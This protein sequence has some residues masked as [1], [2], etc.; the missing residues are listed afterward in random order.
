MQSGWWS[1]GS[2]LALLLLLSG[3]S[4]KPAGIT[5]QQWQLLTPAQ[6]QRAREQLAL[7]DAE[8]KARPPQLATAVQPS[9]SQLAEES[10]SIPQV[11][12]RQ[13]IR[14]AVAPQQAWLNGQWQPA[15]PLLL[16][17]QQDVE[18]RFAL[19]QPGTELPGYHSYGYARFDGQTLSLCRF[20]RNDWRHQQNCALL[21]G[22]TADWQAG[23]A[24]Q[25]ESPS[26]LRGSVR[27]ENLPAGS[28]RRGE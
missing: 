24:G 15:E 4:S 14:C 10:L 26:L 21:T 27:C 2:C 13:A 5:D 28:M 11:A 18:Q 22:S 3:C 25:L 8:A 7:M 1:A 16:E 12:A 20:P 19:T 17:L 9:R 6:Q 23:H